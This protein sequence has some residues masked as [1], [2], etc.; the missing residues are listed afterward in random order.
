A[1]FGSAVIYTSQTT[2]TK[3][4]TPNRRLLPSRSE[5]ICLF[6]PSKMERL[7]ILEKWPHSDDTFIPGHA[8]TQAR[9]M[10]VTV[11]SWR[12]LTLRQSIDKGFRRESKCTTTARC[13]A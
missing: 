10:Q 7:S 13:T 2:N 5:A 11:T 9:E 8:L 4:E 6:T 12:S 3:T 1:A